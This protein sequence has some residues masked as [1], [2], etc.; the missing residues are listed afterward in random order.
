M[1]YPG[2]M[3][4][5]WKLDVAGRR[6]DL[7]ELPGDSGRARIALTMHD[8]RGDPQGGKPPRQRS[9]LRKV[10]SIVAKELID[11]EIDMQAIDKQLPGQFSRMPA[12]N[13]VSGPGQFA[14]RPLDL[15][16]FG[17]LHGRETCP[18]V[19]ELALFIRTEQCRSIGAI[20]SVPGSI[21]A[22]PGE[23]DQ[24]TYSGRMCESIGKSECG[25]PGMPQHNPLRETPMVT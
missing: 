6:D 17:S 21:N 7:S 5:V 18:Q 1:F 15:D 20:F 24:R 25:S 2:E 9:L 19:G 11:Q 14:V 16:I 8:Q 23:V 13:D 22:R 10:I 3:S 12:V 4:N